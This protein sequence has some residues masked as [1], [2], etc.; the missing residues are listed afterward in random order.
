MTLALNHFSIRTT[1]MESTRIFYEAALGLTVGPRPAFPFPGIWLYNGSHADV[2]NAMVHVIGMDLNDPEGLKQYLGDRDISSLKGS[3]AVDHI[4]LF[5]T[6]LQTKLESLA[7][8]GIAV[9][10]RTV[11]SIGLHQLFL[12]DPN[13]VVIELNYPAAEKAALD[14]SR[15]A[16]PTP[17][18]GG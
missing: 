7:K 18:Q 8:L 17:S 9:R 12:D 14:A 11:P 5:D 10:E 15:A 6:G 4:A 13:G 16:Q 1:D 3:G 2:A